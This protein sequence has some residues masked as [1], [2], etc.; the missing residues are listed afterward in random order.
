MSMAFQLTVSEDYEYS[1]NFAGLR[2]EV[3]RLIREGL[4][5][6]TG[7]DDMKMAWTMNTYFTDIVK[8]KGVWLQGWP[9]SYPFVDFSTKSG[10]IDSLRVLYQRLVRGE[11]RWEHIPAD[12]AR[13]LDPVTA[14]P[15]W[16]PKDLQ[17]V[18]RKDI[19]STRKHRVKRPRYARS[20]AKTPSVIDSTVD[21]DVEEI[22]M[23]TDDEIK[24]FVGRQRKRACQY[25]SAEFVLEV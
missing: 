24:E 18:G 17:K 22:E 9:R 12:V 3:R 10:G 5:A 20:G 16:V 11:L 15:S 1:T 14:A 21:P 4:R 19:G 6:I 25:K 23:F 2:G 13:M 8:A 7:K